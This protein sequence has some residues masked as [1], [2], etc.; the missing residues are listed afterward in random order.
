MDK[1]AFDIVDAQ[2]NLEDYP[3]TLSIQ[4]S[5][6]RLCIISFLAEYILKPIPRKGQNNKKTV[7][8]TVALDVC[9][10]FR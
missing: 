5:V 10:I 9:E 6:N 3:N 4:K 8:F 7:T 1:K 2:C